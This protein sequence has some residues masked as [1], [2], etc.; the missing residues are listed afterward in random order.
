MEAG[1]DQSRIFVSCL[2][3]FESG[4]VCYSYRK[5]DREDRMFLH[6]RLISG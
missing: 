5:G 3:T 2:D 6:A 1:I 4:E